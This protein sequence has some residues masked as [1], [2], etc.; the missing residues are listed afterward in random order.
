[1]HLRSLLP[2]LVLALFQKR[3]RAARTARFRPVVERLEDRQLLAV[4]TVFN[5]E[6]AGP[7]SLRQAILDAHSSFEAGTI[8]FNIP[9]S[10]PNFIDVDGSL[11]GGDPEPDA[12]RIQPLSE[13]PALTRTA[14]GII[15]DGRTQT[16]ATGDLNP[17]GPEIVLDGNGIA[18]VGLGITTN[19]HAVRGL[20]IQRFGLGGIVVLGGDENQISGN[21]L[22]VNATGTAAAANGRWGVLLATG[23][24]DNVVGTNSDGL[25]DATERNVISG[26]SLGGVGITGAGSELNVVAGNV[27]GGN[28]TATA[29]IGNLNRG[30][31][32]FSGAQRN[33]IGTNA[34]GV[35]DDLE[36]NIMVGN[37]W[38]G[39][40]FAGAGTTDNVAAGNF[41]GTNAQGAA[42]L[43]NGEDGVLIF[44]G[45]T[46]NVVGG[47]TASARNVIAG[48]AAN[49][50]R[51]SGTGTS[52][53]AVSGNWVGTNASGNAA[54]ANL[55]N[56]LFI[57]S[58]ASNNVVG[59]DGNGTND[60]AEGNLISGNQLSGLRI[61]GN[62]SAHNVVAG[63]RI[64]VDA[65][66]GQALGNKLWGVL[67]S[68]GASDNRLGTNADG[69]S[70]TAERN[71]VSGN[72][73]GGVGIVEQG[74]NRNIVAGN[75]IGTSASGDAAIG[76][77]N[78]GVDVFLGAKQS[79][80]GTNAD[81]VNDASE[82]NV[83]SGNGWEGVSVSDSGTTETLVAG[84]FIGTDA[85]GAIKLPNARSGVIVWDGATLTNVG[86]ASAAAR[87]L[88]SGNTLHGVH[89]TGAATS[90]TTVVGNWIG[91]D[92]TGASDLGNAGHGILIEQGGKQTTI[93]GLAPPLANQIAFNTLNGV[94]ILSA[95]A[96]RN[97]IL[98]N[99]IY[100]N[101]GLGID[102][103]GS[104]AT[105]N[106]ADDS[107]AGPNNLQNHPL[108]VSAGLIGQTLTMRFSVPS[109]ATSAAYPLRIEFFRADAQG[110]EGQAFLGFVD[111]G[112]ASENAEISASFFSAA[113]IADG[114]KIV[115]TATDAAGNTSEFSLPIAAVAQPNP[116]HNSARP[117]D[118]SGDTHVAPNDAL[119]V[120]SFIN[121][122]GSKAVPGEAPAQAPFYDTSNDGQVSPADALN[123]I[124][125]I[126][127]GLADS[128][129]ENPRSTAASP[130]LDTDLLVLLSGDVAAAAKPRRAR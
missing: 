18:A 32:V 13:L 61:T 85:T 41:I 23:A 130:A 88:V 79:R 1:M 93:G 62:A 111:Y 40:A 117:L 10:D 30:V 69:V 42:G 8:V 49:G 31:D 121:A 82:R 25:D 37:A 110:Q 63:N 65:T 29:P 108:L 20:N 56:G 123:I 126:N 81:G 129:G 47:G 103:G 91:L 16:T 3:G 100:S 59:T 83:I 119:E 34:D 78:R 72:L 52:Q 92:A 5:T 33:R 46:R 60:A 14:S 51:I 11:P 80:V 122:F 45:A 66:G 64:G 105:S 68:G 86:G 70:D 28:A 43:G 98:R 21:Y 87:N 104:G 15:I 89:V 109:A 39:L 128:E 57:D 118:V 125:A 106:D 9:T 50:V 54:L 7:G 76:N 112:T 67:F 124:N 94:T 73:S 120:I 17:F 74:T 127:A 77:A 27:I 4:F 95:E 24:S 35:A 115:A 36:G 113:F 99:A 48:N 102:L 55:A 6:N 38:A 97:A 44:G 101:L 75:Y 19:G 71:V 90:Q 107:D 22:G 12:W 84:N 58:G 96:N 26:N 2:S 53:N 114:D 116:W